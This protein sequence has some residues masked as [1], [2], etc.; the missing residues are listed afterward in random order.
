M[1]KNFELLKYIPKAIFND[2]ELTVNLDW[3]S[4]KQTVEDKIFVGSKAIQVMKFTRGIK[5]SN[6]NRFLSNFKK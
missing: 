4:I 1:I 6:D 3:N 5:T 2:A